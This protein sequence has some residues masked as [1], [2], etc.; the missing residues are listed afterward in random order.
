MPL[1]RAAEVE[2][3]EEEAKHLRKAGKR[4]DDGVSPAR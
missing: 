4:F 3:A 1:I 2:V